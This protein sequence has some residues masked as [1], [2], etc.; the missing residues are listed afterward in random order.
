[1]SRHAPCSQSPSMTARRNRGIGFHRAGAAALVAVTLAH[2]GCRLADRGAFLG[3]DKASGEKTAAPVREEALQSARVWYPPAVPIAQADLS[4]NPSGPDGFRADEDVSCRFVV[5]HGGGTTPKFYCEVPGGEVLKVKYGLA[6]P[7]L[8]A[9]VAATRLLT[10]LGFGAD[11]MFVVRTVRCAGCPPFPSAALGCFATLGLKRPCFA[12]GLDEARTVE[13]ESAVIERRTEGRPIEVTGGQGW[14]WYELEKIDPARG[15][16]PRADVDALRLLAI[17]IAHWDNKA[18]NQRLFC[19]PGAEM[20]D[21]G[22][23]RP[24][25]IVQDLGATFGP[26]KLD[27]RNWKATSVWKDRATC[28][29]SMKRLP[30]EGATFP[31]WRI[32]EGGRQRLL[33]LLGELTDPQLRDLFASSRIT[34]YDQ[35]SAEARD[36]QAWVSVFHDKVAQVRAGGPCPQ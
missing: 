19:P 2:P 16:S 25:A 8:A 12:L 18:E 33:G 26:F 32:S 29:V 13:F 27:L 15:G 21:G 1:M 3:S 9:E 17:L 31:D 14:A 7:E 5:K 6:N 4:S 35:V 22:C 36:P 23:T 10:A 30:W 20:P 28:T 34:S 24:M 11:R